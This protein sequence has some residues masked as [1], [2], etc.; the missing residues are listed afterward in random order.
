MLKKILIVLGSFIGLLIILGI[1]LPKEMSFEE[2]I[3]INKPKHVVFASLISFQNDDWT[4]WQKKDP[5]MKKEFKGT[6]GTVGSMSSWAGNAE[7]GVGEQE[8]KKIVDGQRVESELRFK[9]P[10]ANTSVAAFD[11][12]SVGENQ[13]KV[14]W[15]F[16]GP[17]PFPMNIICLLL[18]MKKQMK[19]DMHQGLENLKKK[20]ESQG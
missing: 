19:A 6:D 1:A 17:N 3:V 14:K 9:E 18:N 7:V 11:T 4:V 15:T 16:S 10:F 5:N 20:L 12:E 2:E 8:I 13:T